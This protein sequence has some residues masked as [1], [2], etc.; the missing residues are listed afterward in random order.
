M[1]RQHILEEIRRTAVEGRPLGRTRFYTETGIREHDWLGQYW[2]SWSDAVIEAGFEPLSFNEKFDDEKVFKSILELT[3]KL[4]KFPTIPEMQLE[5]K[6]N[7]EFPN[8]RVI[9]RRWNRGEL[10]E[11]LIKFCGTD[12]QFAD[13]ASILLSTPYK[14]RE[15]RTKSD[16]SP[17]TVSNEQG[18]V[19]AIRAQGAYKIGCTRA[20]YRRAA[21][22]ANQS[23][24][25]AE[26][27][28]LISTDDPE[29]IEKYWHSRFSTKRLSGVNKQSG[30]WFDLSAED[31]SAFKK[32]K[33]M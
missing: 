17:H 5:R 3:R 10:I 7:P 6:S 32:R 22:I 8:N 13:V 24:R 20:P 31:I 33:F 21:E 12:Q 14:I 15:S 4:G 29:G 2:K 19:Y 27:V 23:A 11:A 9:G 16:Q 28:H 18:Y 1:E 30:E 25:G 26:L